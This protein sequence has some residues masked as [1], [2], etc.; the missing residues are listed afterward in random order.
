MPMI[1]RNPA[2][3]ESRIPR[4]ANPAYQHLPDTYASE[5]NTVVSIWRQFTPEDLS[6]RAAPP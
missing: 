6:Y 5:T 1:Y 4:S 3:P 2:I